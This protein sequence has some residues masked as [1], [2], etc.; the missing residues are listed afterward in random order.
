ML[1]V[2]SCLERLGTAL[3]LKN[4]LEG[5]LQYYKKAISILENLP[6][7]DFDKLRLAYNDSAVVFYEKG[8]Y[9]KA[10]EYLEKS[11]QAAIKAHSSVHVRVSSVTENIGECYL[12]IGDF[13]MAIQYYQKAKLILHKLYADKPNKFIANNLANFGFSYSSQGK[14]EEA[15]KFLTTSS[16]MFEKIDGNWDFALGNITTTIGLCLFKKRNKFG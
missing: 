10:K 11:L 13:D 2:A 14:F 3:Y 16:E 5:A 15:L 1:E 6:K 4:D 9:E 7:P 12:N 8:N